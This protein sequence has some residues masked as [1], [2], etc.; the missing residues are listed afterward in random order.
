L[1]VVEEKTDD[2]MMTKRKE[3]GI[4]WMERDGREEGEG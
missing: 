2:G 1:F 3:E 4:G